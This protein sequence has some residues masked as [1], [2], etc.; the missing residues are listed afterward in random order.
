MKK[1][2]LCLSLAC[3]MLISGCSKMEET[4]SDTVSVED[5]AEKKIE[6]PTIKSDD[7]VMPL[8]FDISLYDEEDYAQIYLGKGFKFDFS[9]G[10]NQMKL[11]SSFDEISGE[12]WSVYD[13]QYNENSLIKAGETIEIQF[14]NK[15]GKQLALTFFNKESSS[16]KLSECAVVKYSVKENNSIKKGCVYDQFSINGI[17]NFSAITDVIYTLGAPSHFETFYE[18]EYRL[19][20]FVS[21]ADRRDRITVIIDV[22]NDCVNGVEIAKY[23]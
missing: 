20:Y 12:G 16:L 14:A 21:K 8:Y 5:V 22:Q 18:N 11:P 15:F 7:Q 6:I 13:S 9:Y 17:S 19:H 3:L 4:T 10:G 23:N 2:L 1:L